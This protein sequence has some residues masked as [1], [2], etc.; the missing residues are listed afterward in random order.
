MNS[1]LTLPL[2]TKSARIIL[3]SLLLL[4]LVAIALVLVANAL[5]APS[6]DV[7]YPCIVDGVRMAGCELRRFRR[8]IGVLHDDQLGAGQRSANLM[9][10]G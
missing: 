9:Q 4:A 6:N 7:W 10:V 1:L 2:H 3:T 5:A 8:M